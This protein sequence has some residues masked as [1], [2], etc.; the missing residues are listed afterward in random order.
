[1]SLIRSLNR[2]SRGGLAI[3]FCFL[4]L[5]LGA[6]STVPGANGALGQKVVRLGSKA[7]SKLIVYS[8]KPPY[9]PIA[10]LNYIQGRVKLDI[11]VSRTGSVTEAHVV[12]GEPLLAAVAI[13]AVRKW[14][15]RPFITSRGPTPFETRVTVDF[16]LHTRKITDL[17]ENGGA[18]LQKQIRPP[19]VLAGSRS[20]PP[21]QSVKLKLLVGSKGEVLDSVPAG[22]VKVDD[23]FRAAQEKVRHWKFRAA[24]WGALA[25]PWYLVVKVPVK[26]R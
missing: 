22:K 2:P 26:T 13:E 8:E 20:S 24:R 25:I 12:S 6:A 11:L 19:E 18:F 14:R 15:F 16:W 7:A 23:D 17:P 9:P 5:L 21:A 3:F 4:A 10:K 1:L